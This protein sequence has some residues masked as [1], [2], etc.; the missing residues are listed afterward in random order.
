M[1]QGCCWALGGFFIFILYLLLD[2]VAEEGEGR[3]GGGEDGQQGQRRGSG[4][5][6]TMGGETLHP[7]R[8]HIFCSKQQIVSSLTCSAVRRNS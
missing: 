7:L 5:A 8:I 2:N 4:G 3:E 6:E 1:A